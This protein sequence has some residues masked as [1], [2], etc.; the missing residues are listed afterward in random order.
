MTPSQSQQPTPPPHLGR[1]GR[2]GRIL[3]LANLQLDLKSNL[4]TKG[5]RKSYAIKYT[6]IMQGSNKAL[7]LTSYCISISSLNYHLAELINLAQ[8]Q[9]I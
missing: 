3:L 9:I 6:E 7:G 1:R 5:T 2:S 8:P 4:S